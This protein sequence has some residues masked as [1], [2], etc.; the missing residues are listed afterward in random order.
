MYPVRTVERAITILLQI[1][2]SGEP[3]GVSEISRATGVDKATAL[4]IL[5]TLEQF[6]L[7]DRDAGRRYVPGPGL[8]RLAASWR[9][10]LRDIAEP[11]LQS[12]RRATGEAV[13]LVSPRGMERVIV[14]ALPGTQELSVIPTVGQSHPIY[15]GASGK[16]FMAF[17]PEAE[18]AR[19]IEA[20]ALKPLTPQGITD[21]AT[22]LA[23]LRQV[24]ADGYAVST[25]DVTPGASA[26]AA[27]VFDASPRLVAAVSL[28]APSVR[29]PAERIAQAAPLVIEAADAISR[30]LGH[31]PQP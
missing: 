12:L 15:V 10:D 17:M 25:G 22:F 13:Q 5:A 16:V 9:P 2:G 19:I 14:L 7:V 23:A 24:L 1:A 20:T 26:I 6:R 3:I 4:R 30:D 28:R 11:H 21:R 31:A 8:A 27:P 29:M 18:R